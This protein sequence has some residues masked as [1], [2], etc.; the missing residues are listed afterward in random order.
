MGSKSGMRPRRGEQQGIAASRPSGKPAVA[1]PADLAGWVLHRDPLLLVL[2]KPAGLPVHA[3]PS[4][5]AS[6]EDYLP[7]LRFGYRETPALAH[8]LDQDTSGCLALGRN[9]RALRKLGRLF[10]EGAVEKRYWALAVGRPPAEEGEIDLPLAKV[11]GR[12]GWRMAVAPQGQSA[13]THYRVLGRADGASWLE[14]R[15]RSGRTHQLRVHLAALGCPILGDPLYGGGRSPDSRLHL[16]A[17]ALT[18]PLHHDAEPVSVTAPLP[19]ALQAG[20]ALCGWTPA[21][22]AE[23]K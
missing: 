11:T 21:G 19:A 1:L 10:A 12:G 23:R 4:G 22:E 5:K 16:H 15:P 13:V 8:R 2:N 7:G 9:R 20:M 18:L 3:G 6:L 14:L 17:R